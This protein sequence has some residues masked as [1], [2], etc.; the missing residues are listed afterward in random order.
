MDV[1]HTPESTGLAAGEAP[2]WIRKTIQWSL[3]LSVLVGPLFFLP[4]TTNPFELN[5]ALL[6][7]LLTGVATLAWLG[8]RIWYRWQPP[9]RTSFDLLLSVFLLLYIIAAALSRDWFVSLTGTS[10]YTHHTV[11][12]VALSL[13]WTIVTISVVRAWPELRGQLIRLFSLGVGVAALI[14]FFQVLGVN[15]FPWTDVQGVY[16]NPVFNSVVMLGLVLVSAIPVQLIQLI[17]KPTRGWSLAILLSVLFEL[18]TLIMIDSTIVWYALIGVVFCLVLA[19]GWRGKDIDSR[20][21]ILPTFILIIAAL[22]VFVDASRFTTIDPVEDIVLDQS[23]SWQVSQSTLAQMPLFGIGPENFA[24][25]FTEYR[26]TEFNNTPYW[27]LTFIKSGSEFTQLLVTTGLLT[28]LAWLA[29]A[30]VFVRRAWKNLKLEADRR[31]WFEF[32]ALGIPWLM[33]MVMGFF[34]PMS[35]AIST[36][37][38]LFFALAVSMME[39]APVAATPMTAPKPGSSYFQS[40][41]FSLM[42]VLFVAF[43]F[44]GGKLWWADVSAQA[45]QRALAKQEFI[46]A[47][48]KFANAINAN[49]RRSEYYFGL[50]QALAG[51]VLQMDTADET[52]VARAQEAVDAAL[53]A[54]NTALQLQPNDTSTYLGVVSLYQTLAS[55]LPPVEESVVRL[56]DKMIELDPEHPAYYLANGDALVAYGQ[57]IEAAVEENPEIENKDTLVAQVAPSFEKAAERYQKASELKKDYVTALLKK[58]ALPQLM[59]DRAK[60][61][62][63]VEAVVQTYPN[64]IDA[65]YELARLYSLEEKTDQAKAQYV[66]ILNLDANH[67]NAAYRLGEILQTEGDT[68]SAKVLFRRVYANNPDNQD[69]IAKLEE[70]G[71]DVAAE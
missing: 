12:M 45:G 29:I 15:L 67:A 11:I 27:N 3:C 9:M 24:R 10:A 68:E 55:V 49:D 7:G 21:S 13:M 50:G 5:K 39:K 56:Y 30:V 38:W 26:S 14:S 64:S 41:A 19:F 20:W 66:A 1:M 69:V 40:V 22:L 53:A 4:G 44:L 51:E 46:V 33:V 35:F 23:T 59:G 57:R 71:V 31:R 36:L 8:G 63:E 2:R 62:T 25:A 16:F 34:Y 58:A 32:I 61:V 42:A 43:I 65:R 17:Q 70:L 6:F 28:T 52:K 37:G 18:A 48:E 54:A 47:Q 60:A